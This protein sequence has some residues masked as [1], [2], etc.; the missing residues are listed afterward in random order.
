MIIDNRVFI[1]DPGGSHIGGRAMLA[2]RSDVT[3]EEAERLIYLEGELLD[4]WRLDDWLK[5]YSDDMIYLV[6]R[7]ACRWIA[8][9][10]QLFRSTTTVS[11]W[12]AASALE[13]TNG[14]FRV[15]ATPH[16]AHV[17]EPA[18]D[19][20]DIEGRMSTASSMCRDYRDG[21]RNSNVPFVS[22]SA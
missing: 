15:S 19:G 7:P 18:R 10:T 8:R 20:Q 1:D 3:I 16:G 4:D 13:E 5:L 6:R 21:V 11:A 17:L 22:S 14:T 2:P 12:K 9:P